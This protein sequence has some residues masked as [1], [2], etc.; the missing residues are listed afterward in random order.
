MQ[1]MTGNA[2][3]VSWMNLLIFMGHLLCQTLEKVTEQNRHIP[4][5]TVLKYEL[6][7]IVCAKWKKRNQGIS[8]KHKKGG[9]GLRGKDGRSRANCFSWVLIGARISLRGGGIKR[10]KS[11][12]AFSPGLKQNCLQS[13]HS[14]RDAQLRRSEPEQQR[15]VTA[16]ADGRTRSKGERPLGSIHPILDSKPTTTDT[17]YKESW[18]LQSSVAGQFPLSHKHQFSPERLLE[19]S[20]ER[21]GGTGEN[22]CCHSLPTLHF[23]LLALLEKPPSSPTTAQGTLLSR[24]VAHL[25]HLHRRNWTGIRRWWFREHKHSLVL[26]SS[27]HSPH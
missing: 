1:N 9:S 20:E 23:P 21:Q 24:S 25:L 3:T 15:I 18:T 6:L 22:G 26:D 7:K 5:L 4:I 8:E 16:S 17:G 13:W 12:R 27:P 19:C 14:L 2:S 10:E 11:Q